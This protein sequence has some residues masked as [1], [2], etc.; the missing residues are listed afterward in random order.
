MQSAFY[1]PPLATGP[2]KKGSFAKDMAIGGTIGAISKTIMSPVER[3]KILMQTM[4]SNPKVLSGEI[5]PYKGI[6]DCFA[7]VKA[8]QGVGAFWRG[9]LVNCLRYAPQQGSALAFND[10][11]KGIFPKVDKNQ[12]FWKFMGYNL[13]SGGMGGATAMV[14]CYPM[15]FA[16][17]RLASDLGAGKGQFNGIADCLQKTVAQQG[18]TGLYRGTAVSVAGAFVYRAGQLGLYGT[19]MGFNP[20]KDDK[21]LKGFFS[22][23]VIGT[24]ARTVVL[25]FNYPFDTVRRRLMLESEKP[26]AERTYKSGVDCGVKVLKAEGLAG[27]YKGL[28]SEVFRG[29]GGV[30]VI[31]MYDRIKNMLDMNEE[32][33]E[34]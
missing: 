13:A 34:Q 2:K 12:E 17:T 1:T 10:F 14:I 24:L 6:G 19:V 27:M 21:G 28:V 9:N 23:V 16:R 29:F 18:I 33:E 31:V 4:D 8:E 25:P 7:R 11:F 26:A 3:V 32:E 22:A 15:D 5:E 30:M 20:Y